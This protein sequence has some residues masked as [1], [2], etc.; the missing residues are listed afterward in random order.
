MVLQ[1]NQEEHK[2]LVV[3]V[4]VQAQ[5]EKLE[6]A[7]KLPPE[8]MPLEAAEKPQAVEEPPLEVVVEEADLLVEED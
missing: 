6:V 1:L 7:E 8:V 2:G 4:E 3:Q 5:V